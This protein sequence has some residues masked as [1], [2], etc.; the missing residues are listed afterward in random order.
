MTATTSPIL[1]Y[2]ICEKPKILLDAYKAAS[3]IDAL[4]RQYICLKDAPEDIRIGNKGWIELMPDQLLQFEKNQDIFI[5]AT[6]MLLSKTQPFSKPLRNA[7]ISYLNWVKKKSDEFSALDKNRLSDPLFSNPDQICFSGYLPLPHPKIP[8]CNETGDFEGAASFELG[9]HISGIV[10]LV[11]FS[12]GEFVRRSERDL[13]QKLFKQSD[14]FKLIELP[15]PLDN[16]ELDQAFINKLLS[17]IPAIANFTE[18]GAL[19]HG[20]Y[21]PVGLS[22]LEEIG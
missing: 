12:D 18:L 13:R 20:L 5:F 2:G 3:D 19:P 15:K 14:R 10:Y 22:K 6:E 4:N 9:F 8:V 16:S 17:S 21:Y 1:I 7:L 11:S